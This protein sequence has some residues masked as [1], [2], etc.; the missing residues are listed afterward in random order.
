MDELIPVFD[1][2]GS[3]FRLQLRGVDLLE[4]RNIVLG[5]NGEELVKAQLHNSNRLDLGQGNLAGIEI[6]GGNPSS[7]DDV[8]QNIV[9]SRGDCNNV[10]IRT[11]LEDLRKQNET[12]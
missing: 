8:I 11:E 10:V 3:H 12:E 9:T 4:E 2:L 6:D 1:T 5:E 7:L